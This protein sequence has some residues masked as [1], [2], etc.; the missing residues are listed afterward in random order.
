MASQPNQIDNV[1]YDAFGQRTVS[2]IYNPLNQYFV[3]MEVAPAYWQYPQ[4]LN[5]IFLSTAAG[6]AERHAA[7]ADAAAAPCQRRDADGRRVSSASS[8]SANTNSLNA[9]AEANQQTNSISNS[10]GGSSSGSAD[11]T[12]AETMVPLPAMMTCTRTAT[13]RRR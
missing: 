8:T 6:N 2:T 7:D 5:R 12:A 4:S 11:S 3:V 10:K 1:L 13:P 9:D